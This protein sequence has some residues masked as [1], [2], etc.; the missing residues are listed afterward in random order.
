MSKIGL[1]LLMSCQLLL[2]ADADLIQSI[3]DKGTAYFKAGEYNQAIHEF[4]Q[5]MGKSLDGIKK[6]IV[7]YNLATSYL[8]NKEYDLAIAHLQEVYS[9]KERLPSYM[10]EKCGVNLIFSQIAKIEDLLKESSAT[11]DELKGAMNTILALETIHHE[12]GLIQEAALFKEQEALALSIKIAKAKV[13]K[14]IDEMQLRAYSLDEALGQLVKT[15]SEYYLQY[16]RL[17]KKKLEPS[18]TRYFLNKQFAKEAQLED[19]WTRCNHLIVEALENAKESRAPESKKIES[20]KDTQVAFLESQKHY[21]DAL[22]CMK[23]SDVLQ[24]HLKKALSKFYLEIA[25]IHLSQGDALK[26]CFTKRIDLAYQD[27]DDLPRLKDEF[28]HINMTALNALSQFLYEHQNDHALTQLTQKL[29]EGLETSSLDRVHQ[30]KRD[31]YLYAQM[32][33]E[34]TTIIYP[35]YE[36]LVKSE[37]IEAVLFDQYLYQ[38]EACVDYLNA[39]KLSS[40]QDKN[41]HKYEQSH[42][43]VM[44]AKIALG[45]KKLPESAQALAHFLLLWDYRYFMLEQ[46]KKLSQN[47]K[48]CIL[49]NNLDF[50]MIE[51]LTA[52]LDRLDQERGLAQLDAWENEIDTFLEKGLQGAKQSLNMCP[53]APNENCQKLLVENGNQWMERLKN[54]LDSEELTSANIL[55]NGIK[56]QRM[57]YQ[58]ADHYPKLDPVPNHF[59]EDFLQM[60]KEAENYPILAVST[61]ESKY[62]NEQTLKEDQD[63]QALEYFYQGLKCA[64]DAQ[65]ALNQK[66]IDWSFVVTKEQESID[67]WEKALAH[68]EQEEQGQA[69][70]SIAQN[71][72]KE[73]SSSIAELEEGQASYQEDRNHSSGASPVMSILERLNEMEQDDQIVKA[74]PRKTTEGLRPW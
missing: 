67:Y 50:K 66:I 16:E 17:E 55:Q 60:T 11:L 19:L 53:K 28:K 36:Q 13:T 30:L 32:T 38:I 70:Q 47:F 26:H 31:Y 58:L 23:A 5:A 25:N 42:D 44:D 71:E 63:G 4:K 15:A 51:E 45:H 7:S 35:I 64:K 65:N 20:L 49:Q 48:H 57:A 10:V 43:L 56:E 72:K 9:H 22:E 61:F 62:K 24:G 34:P 12:L 68:Y 21:L 29:K 2:G 39:Y 14:Q 18:L 3:F 73:Q 37:N 8:N 1:S 59:E 27:K 40:A 69:G 41:Y 33:N 52:H 74:V 6:D 54:F 46:I